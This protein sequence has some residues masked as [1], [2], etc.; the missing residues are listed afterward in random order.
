VL[1]VAMPFWDHEPEPEMRPEHCCLPEHV[2]LCTRTGVIDGVVVEVEEG[3][4]SRP[5]PTVYV[6][7]H[8][9]LRNN[10]N[11]FEL[12]YELTKLPNLHT[13]WKWVRRRL[14]LSLQPSRV[15]SS[16]TIITSSDAMGGGGPKRSQVAR[17]ATKGTP[18][19]EPLCAYG[20]LAK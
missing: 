5:E 7:R 4:A 8:L 14:T 20:K 19:G 16:N 1:H 9:R 11:R 12:A 17:K 2:C 10:S 18:P 13:D 6:S 3:D 15:R